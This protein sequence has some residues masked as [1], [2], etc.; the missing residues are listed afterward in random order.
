MWRASQV[1]SLPLDYI[2]K[3]AAANGKRHQ[4]VGAWWEFAEYPITAHREGGDYRLTR[5]FDLEFPAEF[6]FD[7]HHDYKTG[8]TVPRMFARKLD[9]RNPEVVG[10]IKYVWDPSRHQYLSAIAFSSRPDAEQIVSDALQ[11]WIDNNPY[12]VGVNW[13]SSLE[14]GLRL[15]SWSLIYPTLR[16]R[17]QRDAKFRDAFSES[18]FLHLKSIRG[19]L[20]L[21]SSA[22]NHLIGELAGLYVGSVCFPWWKECATWRD[23]AIE[24]LEREVQLQFTSEGVNR[25]QAMSYQLFTLEMLLIVLLVGR[26]TGHE[27]S[28]AFRG[29]VRAALDYLASLATPAGDLP[30]FGD[31]DDARG[32]VASTHEN[33]FQVVMQ[34]GGMLFDEPRFTQFAPEITA[35]GRALMPSDCAKL[36]T[37]KNASSTVTDTKFLPEGG[38]AVVQQDDWKLVMDVG[39]LG[40]T[41]IAAHGH[42]DALSLTLA[43]GDK[44]VLV[45]SGTYA[46][47]SHPEWRA[48]F[49]GTA[50]HNTA[51]VDG[52]DQSTAAGRFLWTSKANVQVMEWFDSEDIARIQAQHDGYLRLSD[53]VLHQRTTT[54][55]KASGIIL[56]E[57]SFIWKDKHDV[58]IHWHLSEQ[59]MLDQLPDGTLLG[60][61]N[62]YCLAFSFSGS[63]C[64]VTVVQGSTSPILGLRSQSFNHKIPISTIRCSLVVA[65]TT[66]VVTQIGL[67]RSES[68]NELDSQ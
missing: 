64:N 30:W 18:V 34:L 17:L 42:A 16:S 13:T 22:N 29:R 56:V 2:G 49:R 9:I 28:D 8:K 37:L 7:W 65:G 19:H 47:H 48:Y 45:D 54:F 53:P 36:A 52:F 12:L 31:S 10:D 20:S 25:E 59:V 46:Y 35:T 38:I 60:T 62:E 55:N 68:G 23:F 1:L 40:Y 6:E 27:F 58:E 33:A 57:D 24:L 44:Y 15:I 61:I 63:P 32:F 67:S 3:S 43:A 4:P 51:R 14:V 5:I 50:A 21:Y 26:N 11:S 39:P 66:K 41:S